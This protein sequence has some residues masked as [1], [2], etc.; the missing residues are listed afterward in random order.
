MRTKEV[1]HANMTFVT[2]IYEEGDL[3][4]QKSLRCKLG[5]H[6]YSKEFGGFSKWARFPD[7]TEIEG[8]DGNAGCYWRF[9][10]RCGKVK[11]T[12]IHG[13]WG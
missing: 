11:V 6:D 1:T 4:S 3:P 5:S 8:H 2:C 12:G 10:K 13:C 7:G 9:C